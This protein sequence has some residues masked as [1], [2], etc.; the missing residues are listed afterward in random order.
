MFTCVKYKPKISKTKT[1][2]RVRV[3][4]IK[5]GFFPYNELTMQT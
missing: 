5:Y 2:K 4:V 3:A 1:K